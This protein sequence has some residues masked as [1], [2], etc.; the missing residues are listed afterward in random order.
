MRAATIDIEIPFHDVDSL[1]IV[2][3]GHYYKYMDQAR[4]ALMRAHGLDELGLEKLGVGLVVVESRCRYTQS[5]RFGD[6][7]RVTA[8]FTDVA[9]QDPRIHIAYDFTHA[10]T[11]AR[12]ARG[13]TALVFT[14]PAGNLLAQVP[15][16]ILAKYR[17]AEPG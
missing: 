3:F 2:W 5:L 8:R 6:S 11:G 14:D 17:A 10:A 9:E 13:R 7:V 12:V 4:T 1:S 15:P 16:P